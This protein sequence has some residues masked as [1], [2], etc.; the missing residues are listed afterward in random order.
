MVEKPSRKL[1]DRIADIPRRILRA[2]SWSAGGGPGIPTD[3]EV[4]ESK[5]R[6]ERETWRRGVDEEQNAPTDGSRTD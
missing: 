4:V 5:R 1:S 2:A 3:A 6:Q